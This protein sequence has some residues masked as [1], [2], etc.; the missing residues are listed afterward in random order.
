MT[1]YNRYI[2]WLTLLF[3][4]TSVIMVFAGVASLK[5]Y[6]S[7]YLVEILALTVL[8][9]SLDPRARRGLSAVN[10]MLFAGFLVLVAAAVVE[11]I[12]GVT[13]L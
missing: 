10:Y 9:S 5:I 12:L 3:V 6:F 1:L 8:F 7:V 2:L 11:I 13:I 4:L